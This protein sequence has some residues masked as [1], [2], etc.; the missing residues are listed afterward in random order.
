VN[1][2]DEEIVLA[3]LEESRENLDQLDRDLVVLESTPSDPALLAQVFRT[4]HTIKGTCGFL[5]FHRLE[6]LTHAGENLLGAL[7]SGDLVLDAGITT[8]LL[9]LVDAVRRILDLIEVTGA[10]AEDD[11]AAVVAALDR[12]LTPTGVEPDDPSASAEPAAAALVTTAAA[13]TSVRVDVAVLDKLMDLVGEL[14][15]TRSR[16]AD[17][18]VTNDDGPL[19][20]PF[21]HLRLV[22]DELQENVMRA[23][24]QPVGTV[25]GKFRRVVRDL[26][27]AMGK[28]ITIDIEGED[29]GVDKAVNEALRDP[30]LHLVRNAV[31]HGI[32]PPAERLAAGKPAMGTL[33]LRAF[34]EG[35]R[36]RIELTDDGRGVDPGRLVE[37]AIASGAL[38]LEEAA[39]LS[40]DETLN[41]MFLPGLSTKDDVTN[42]SGRGVGMDVVR[43]ALELVGGSIDVSSEPGRG[44]VFRLNVPLTLAIMPV[45]IASIGAE[46]YAVPQVDV[47]EVLRIAAEDM[48]ATVHDVDGARIYRLR[49][50]L[51]PL[52][53]LA[54]QF[55]LDR[56]SG[57]E[58][59]VV[60]VVETN[61]RRFGIVVDA[62]GDTTDVVVKPLTRAIRSIRMFAGIT[63]LG[64][65]EPALILDVAGLASS[66]G[67]TATRDHDDAER[68]VEPEDA[69]SMLLVASG[70]DDSRVA[71]G[72]AAVRRLEQIASDSVE[73]WGPFEVVQYRG[74]ILPLVR[75]A[76]MLPNG[77]PT[78][79]V[80]V[81]HTVVCESSIGMVGLVVGRIEDVVARPVAAAGGQPPDRRGVIETLV[82]N[83]RVTELLDVEM[84]IAD[85]G[86]G[87]TA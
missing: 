15:L 43:A 24:L 31:D 42:I 45:L 23:R 37:K 14:V 69:A 18:E 12:H 54:E 75:V 5:G 11:H 58:S 40:A 71:I 49:D 77:T 53:D 4:I 57:A 22:T 30:L 51:V 6:T 1:E 60:V 65:G 61:R 9:D 83:S 34:H 39:A 33:T 29:I 44:S 8:T 35:G 25:T 47:H 10:E 21:R 79:P 16:F 19:A 7:R 68:R 52:V 84:L 2:G 72:M 55:H 70:A 56:P 59:L 74:G 32:E 62:I 85:A 38:S 17:S 80:D 78:A 26:A 20:L 73:R 3:F 67:I 64:D 66:A 27:T 48:A 28:Q 63:I 46:R 81:L 76:D 50:R 82:V 86:I 87:R 13:E 36:V 41:L